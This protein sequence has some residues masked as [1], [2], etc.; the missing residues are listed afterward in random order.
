MVSSENK[1]F[2]SICLIAKNEEKHL[3]RLVDSLEG[4]QDEIILVDTGSSDNTIQV[5][6]ELGMKV[7]ERPWDNS[8]CRARNFSCSKASGEWIFCPDCDEVVKKPKEFLR[9][10]KSVDASVNQ[11]ALYLHISWDYE[12]KPINVFPSQRCFRRGTHEWA[13]DLHEFLTPLP[14]FRSN[15]QICESA[16]FEH[17][18]DINKNRDWYIDIL[19]EQANNN[20]ND[21]RYLH[22]MGRE[23]LYKGLYVEALGYFERCLEYHTWDLERS[24]TR[25]YMSDCYVHLNQPDKAEEQLLL[26][27]KEEPTRRDAYFKLGELYRGQNKHDRAVIWYRACTSVPKTKPRYFTNEDLY[28]ALP[29]LRMA[30]SY[31]YLGDMKSAVEAYNLAKEKEPS[32]PE[33]TQNSHYFDFPLVSIIIPTRF[34]NQALETCLSLITEDERSYPNIEVIVV[35]DELDQPLG[36]PRATNTGV[37]KARGD[38]LVFLGNDCLPQRGWLLHAMRAMKAT[39]PDGKGLISFNDQNTPGRC[40]HFLVHKDVLPLLPYNK[41]GE[42][43]KLFNEEYYHNYIDE[44]LREVMLYNNKF[45]WCPSAVVLHSWYDEAGTGQG[46]K[47]RSKDAC[48]EYAEKHVEEDLKLFLRRR[49]LW[50]RPFSFSAAVMAFRDDTEDAYLEEVLVRLLEILPPDKILGIM[51]PPFSLEDDPN[52]KDEGTQE[53]FKKYGVRVKWVDS[54]AEHER[55]N[56]AIRELDTDYVFIVDSD[57]IWD[58]EDLKKLIVLSSQDP[59]VE[60]WVAGVHNYWKTEEYRIDPMESY[61]APVLVKKIVKFLECRV[62]DASIISDSGLVMHHMSYCK[63]EEVIKRKLSSYKNPYISKLHPVKEG[64]FENVWKKWTPELSEAIENLHPTHPQAW[65][66]AVK[67]DYDFKWRV[68]KK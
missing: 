54:I 50:V 20:P 12:G 57:E 25:I 5:A 65:K 47:T 39:F 68:K 21:P 46:V 31:W 9:F 55:R 51:G 34:R 13:G 28:G 41:P 56:E 15:V 64:W 60:C 42:P 29:F 37:Q 11:I 62:N 23:A 67:H 44:E 30:Y 43:L 4:I 24:Q 18:P 22:Y 8:F 35:R 10:L 38:Y 48:D 6:K 61:R 36:C 40:Q 3:K 52:F 7:Y 66:K 53:L 16:W 45:K 17:H 32:M 27:L 59:N 1:P 14:G 49:P 33:V 26:S 2:L 63:A 19:R 58:P